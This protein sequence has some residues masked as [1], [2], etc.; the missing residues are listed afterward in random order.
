MIIQNAALVVFIISTGCVSQPAKLYN[1]ALSSYRKNDLQDALPRFELLAAQKGDAESYAWLAET[2]RRLGKNKEALT[3]ARTSLRLDP[4]NSFAHTVVADVSNPMY[5]QWEQS[6]TDTTWAHLKQ[7][8]E[9][10]PEDGNAWLSFSVEAMK[11]RDM[12]G[13]Q[14]A[15]RGMVTSGFLTPTALAFG[16]WL[17]RALPPDAVLVTNG[18]MDTFPP[19]AVQVTEGFRADV[20]VVN[21][22]LLNSREYQTYVREVVRLPADAGDVVVSQTDTLLPADQVFRAWIHGK[23]GGSFPRPIALACTIDQDWYR[24]YAADFRF[25][26]PFFL[27]SRDA[28]PGLSVASLAKISLEGVPPAQFIGPFVSDQD[29]SPIRHTT[30]NGLVELVIGTSVMNGTLSMK[31]GQLADA[32]RWID[33]AEEV[34]TKAVHRLSMT[35]K[36]D[37]LK[38]AMKQ[39]EQ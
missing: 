18:D 30:S 5:G 25:C 7:A 38:K 3:N 29:R 23:L 16:R 17:L 26:G 24:A 36:I 9:C 6:N 39:F 11:N 21:R 22:S 10:N 32:Q 15:L 19:W 8:V 14:R 2:C 27:W 12:A 33:W 20:S 13:T 37:E 28:G 35:E 1:D 4:C 34:N 31:G